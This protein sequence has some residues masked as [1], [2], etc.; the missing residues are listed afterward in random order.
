MT[1]QP[2]DAECHAHL[3]AQARDAGPWD[4]AWPLARQ[5]EAWEA[6][7]RKA[8]ARRPERLLVEDMEIPGE[9]GAIHLRSIVALDARCGGVPE[10][11]AHAISND[12][13]GIFPQ[14]P[15]VTLER[16]ARIIGFKS[17]LHLGF[18]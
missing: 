12:V 7:C 13:A 5:R 11:M 3:A 1:S 2:F 9:A 10:M 18:R 8:R 15:D 16:A 4:P 17:V 6:Q 14:G